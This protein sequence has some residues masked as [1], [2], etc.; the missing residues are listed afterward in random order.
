MATQPRNGNEQAEQ[1]VGLPAVLRCRDVGRKYQRKQVALALRAAACRRARPLGDWLLLAEEICD[2]TAS[3]HCVICSLPG[4]VEAIRS[5]LSTPA[6]KNERSSARG[7]VA[8][9]AL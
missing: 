9:V 5:A 3:S 1:T 7:D 8:L 6:T 4:Q 2:H